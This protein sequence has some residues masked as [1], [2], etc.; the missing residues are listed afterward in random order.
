MKTAILASLLITGLLSYSAHGQAPR[1]PSIRFP[2]NNA[3]VTTNQITVSGNTTPGSGVTLVQYTID[4]NGP[5]VATQLNANN[6]NNWQAPV[7]LTV[8]SNRFRVWDNGPGGASTSNSANYFLV[9]TNAITI[10]ID[11]KGAVEPNYNRKELVIDKDYTVLAVPETGQ[12][13]AGWSGSVASSDPK[14][15]FLMQSNMQLTATFVANPFTSN[16]PPGAYNGLFWDAESPSETNAGYLTL[17]LAGDGV[18]AGQ[19]SVDGRVNTF[20]G[21]FDTNGMAQLTLHRHKKGDLAVSLTMDLSGPNGLTGSVDS[22]GTNGTGAFA[23]Q[24]QAYPGLIDADHR[25][26][27]FDGNYTLAM[28]GAGNGDPAV[29]P[30]GFSYATASVEGDGHVKLSLFL[31]DGATAIASGDLI[32]NGYLPFYVSLYAG[33]GSV[34]G[35]I[36]F[37][38]GSATTNYQIFWFKDPV[39]NHSYADGFS[40]TGRTIWIDPRKAP[41]PGANALDVTNALVQLTGSDLTLAL[42]DPITLNAKGVGSGA[43]TN[44]V[45]I[46]VKDRTGLFTGSFVDPVEGR[47]F[48]IHGVA[49]ESMREGLGY[50][51]ATNHLSG[52]VVITPAP[53]P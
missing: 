5:F 1:R 33:T 26:K 22:A 27:Y 12:F 36:A 29:A 4:G 7:S 18:F 52:A 8:G 3:R 38:N 39:A 35:W 41:A 46:S 15:T 48:L 14:L 50:F 19:I 34:L 6:W 32:A 47:T 16:A 9:V 25:D 31:S 30:Q 40:L 10:S 21:R 23:A 20:G 28:S 51:L 44:V 37:T 24:L 11:G 13:F 2:A 53:V 45:K 42:T 17:T 49:L 43:N